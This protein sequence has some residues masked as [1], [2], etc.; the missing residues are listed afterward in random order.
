MVGDEI[1]K[2]IRF[3]NILVART[4]PNRPIDSIGESTVLPAPM[5]RLLPTPTPA[6]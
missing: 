3:F 6:A 2:Q 4:T 1:V 5:R